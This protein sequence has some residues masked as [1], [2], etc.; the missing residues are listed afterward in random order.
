MAMRAKRLRL[1][2]VGAAVL[3]LAAMTLRELPDEQGHPDP[4]VQE[5]SKTIERIQ[6]GEAEEKAKAIA[7][8]PSLVP[9]ASPCL[10][11][12][13]RLAS[14][15]DRTWR[16]AFAAA[17]VATSPDRRIAMLNDLMARAPDD[18]SRWRIDIAFVELALRSGNNEETRHHLGNAASR[19]VP[20]SCRADEAF[21]A[22]SLASGPGEAIELLDRAVAI[23]PGFWS[24]LE[25]RAVL[26]AAGTGNDPASCEADAV[27]T[28]ET[29]VQLG[30]LAQ[31]DTQFQRLNRALE[32]MPLN[33]RT[34]LLRGMILRQTDEAEA[35]RDAYQRG[36][37]SL[38]PSDCDAI[39]RRGLMGMLAATESDV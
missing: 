37:A 3:V 35:A 20:E 14:G 1:F 21:F 25:Q 27:R 16:H 2:G 18:L 28:L 5:L 6:S 12:R 17:T 24:A 4:V 11:R 8:E 10:M 30:A 33:G 15:V 22:A 23:D 19:T 29:A 13:A 9:M 26:A 36:L 7:D 31:K 34:A 32:A 38:G 39:L